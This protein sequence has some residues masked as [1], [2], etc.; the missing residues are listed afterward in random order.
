MIT[1]AGDIGG[2]NCRLAIY[3]DGAQ[4]FERSYPSA[5]FTSLDA[6]A[7][8]FM[9]EARKAIGPDNAR[10]QRACLGVAGPVDNGTSRAT[11]L[12][13]FIEA[14]KLENRLNIPKVLLVNDFQAAALGVTLLQD[15]QVIKMGGGERNPKGPIVVAGAG[16]GLGESFLVWSPGE[17]RYQ[18]GPH[19]AGQQPFKVG[20]AARWRLLQKDFPIHVALPMRM[21]RQDDRTLTCLVLI[22][23]SRFRLHSRFAK[24]QS[25][26]DSN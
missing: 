10:A 24:P 16:T 23:R 7:E 22:G 14:K 18:Q 5:E 25:G 12:P 21:L 17:D 19:D 1:L 8:K 9:A 26:C 15:D 6:A 4:I 13:W 11:N 3:K 2:T 20:L